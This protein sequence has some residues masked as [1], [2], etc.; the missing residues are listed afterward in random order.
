MGRKRRRQS[1]LAEEIAG[2]F[3]A[4]QERIREAGLVDGAHYTEYVDGVKQLK[5]EKRHA[6]AVALLDNLVE[7]TEA[8][9]TA[10]AEGRGVAPWC[11]EQLAVIYRKEKRFSDEVAILERY[12]AQPKAPGAGPNKLTERLA[13]ARELAVA[14]KT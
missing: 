8:Q 13:K 5:R 9:S 6:E 14:A 12:Q 3:S 4:E 2:D 11:Y 10:A 1:S 7:A